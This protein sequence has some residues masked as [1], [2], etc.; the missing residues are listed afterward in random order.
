MIRWLRER[1]R[2]EVRNM[3]AEELQARSCATP[4]GLEA[5]IRHGTS[6]AI[7]AV[8][9]RAVRDPAYRARLKG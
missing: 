5:A 7:Q 6:S 8:A 9:E 3:V 4:T 1:L 2:R